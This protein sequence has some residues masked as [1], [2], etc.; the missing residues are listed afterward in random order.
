MVCDGPK[1][2]F[3]EISGEEEI[4]WKYINP[5]IRGGP[6]AQGDPISIQENRV[7]K[8]HRYGH[9][10]TG[11]ADQELSAGDPIELNPSSN[12]NIREELISVKENFF[13][14]YPNPINKHLSI[15]II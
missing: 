15:E 11:F 4:V 7:F 13:K 1:G 14:M 8:I 6:I 3:F 5:V 12:E 10:F 9:D 2:L